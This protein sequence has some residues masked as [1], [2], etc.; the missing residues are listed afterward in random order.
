MSGRAARLVSTVLAVPG[1]SRAGAAV[2]GLHALSMLAAAVV[3]P[4]YRRPGLAGA[5]I[6]TASAVLALAGGPTRR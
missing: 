1:T 5:A 4:R 3:L 2:D 6:A